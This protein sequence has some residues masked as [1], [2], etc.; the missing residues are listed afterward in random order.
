M[1]FF[2]GILEVIIFKYLQEFEFKPKK[3]ISRDSEK[4]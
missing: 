1:V 3:N 2:S 4:T